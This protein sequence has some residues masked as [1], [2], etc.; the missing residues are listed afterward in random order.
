MSNINNT[1]NDHDDAVQI[2]TIDSHPLLSHAAGLMHSRSL[3]NRYTR[4]HYISETTKASLDLEPSSLRLQR[5]Y[6]SCAG[7]ANRITSVR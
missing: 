4:T 1:N 5:A 7:L 6:L 3:M 2:N